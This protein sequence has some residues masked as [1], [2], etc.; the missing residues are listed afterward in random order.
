MCG[1]IASDWWVHACLYVSF[2]R[3]LCLCMHG[4]LLYCVCVA[5]DNEDVMRGAHE[6]VCATACMCL[7]VSC[8]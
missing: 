3:I 5:L 1:K 4:R 7:R 2:Y 8:V 6:C